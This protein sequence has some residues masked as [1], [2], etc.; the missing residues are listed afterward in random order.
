[1]KQKHFID[2]NKAATALVM[3]ALMALYDQWQNPTAW[4]YLVLHGAYGLMWVLKSRIFPDRAWEEKTGLA[5]GLVIW[6]GLSLYWVGGWMVMA[7]GVHAP[8]WYQGM[9]IGLYVFGVFAHFTADMQ[10]H[11]MLALRPGQLITGGMFA[12]VRN[13]NYFGEL[14]IYS[15]FG[16][17]AM[18]WLPIV[19]LL[20][21][22]GVIWFPRMRK[23]EA[24]LA[25]LDGFETYRKHTKLFIPYLY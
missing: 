11:V 3:L 10:K 17:L 19:I 5:Y 22:V 15:G 13:I 20:L 9:C 16:L 25:E 6:F 8:A 21:W 7:R 14:L 18:H 24:V 2:T 4:I 1:M 12:R 23:K